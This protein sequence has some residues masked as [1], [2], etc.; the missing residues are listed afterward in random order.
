MSAMT[1]RQAR[2]YDQ[3]VLFRFDADGTT[4][5]FA[6]RLAAENGW[7]A[8][9]ARRVIGEYR[10]FAFLAAAAGHPVSPS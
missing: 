7:S 1:E 9:Y 8:G 3:V 10:R 2:L 6:D 5:T 4:Y